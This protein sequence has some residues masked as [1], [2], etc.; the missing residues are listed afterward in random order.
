MYVSACE[1]GSTNYIICCSFGAGKFLFMILNLNQIS[2][3]RLF[4]KVMGI[5]CLE[6]PMLERRLLIG[7]SCVFWVLFF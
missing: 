3:S 4:V 2:L 5:F 7:G 1:K 6:L